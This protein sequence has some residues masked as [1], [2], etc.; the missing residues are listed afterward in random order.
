MEFLLIGLFL[1]LLLA[2]GGAFLLTRRGG[3]GA[4]TYTPTPGVD[5]TPGVGDDAEVPR[6][7]ATRSVGTVAELPPDTD[8]DLDEFGEVETPAPAPRR[9]WTARSPP[10]GG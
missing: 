9:C 5:Y 6:D 1:V 8:P 4:R 7:S 2:L 3:G 10:P